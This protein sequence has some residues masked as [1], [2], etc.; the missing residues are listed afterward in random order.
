MHVH[1]V[2]LS[3]TLQLHHK[4]A[5]VLMERVRMPHLS[6]SFFT[7]VLPHLPWYDAK[8]GSLKLYRRRGKL[9]NKPAHKNDVEACEAGMPS[10]WTAAARTGTSSAST[11]A[12][13]S[14]QRISSRCRVGL[15]WSISRQQLEE[16]HA[17]MLHGTTTTLA[18][19]TLYCCGYNWNQELILHGGTKAA[20]MVIRYSSA[21]PDVAA[22]PY[23]KATFEAVYGP[24]IHRDE[25]YLKQNAY[26]Q[27]LDGCGHEPEG[28]ISPS[29]MDQWEKYITGGPAAP[30]P[31]T[32]GRPWLGFYLNIIEVL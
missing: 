25:I 22:P 28:I 11:T 10:A 31:Y 17:N 2:V 9:G 12:T 30:A 8:H 16:A 23:L 13:S 19:P 29:T 27:L 20:W 21:L 32:S 18:S 4:E 24:R 26:I 14:H 5:R 3:S 1:A 15:S 7:T 6:V